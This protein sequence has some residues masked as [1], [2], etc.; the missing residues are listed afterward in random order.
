MSKIKVLVVDDAVVVRSLVVKVLG[1]DPDIEVVG[2]AANGKLALAMLEK[3]HPDLITLDI[4]MP[5]MN[6]IETL[7]HIRKSHP[8]LPVI[9]FSTLTERGASSTLE[10]LSRGAS[11]Y[12][13]KP[14]NTGKITESMEKVR[15]DL[16][17]KIKAL[18]A[19]VPKGSGAAGGAQPPSHPVTGRA[20]GGRPG[21]PTSTRPLPGARVS[22]LPGGAASAR[23]GAAPTGAN[24]T[25]T[26]RV[27]PVEIV[28]IGV[29]TGGPNALGELIPALPGNFPV[30][31]LIVQHM[32]P[33]FTRLLAERLDTRSKVKVVEAAPGM[34]IHPGTVY[35]APGEY[36]MTVRREGASVKLAMNQ[37]PPENS[38][39]PAVDPLFRSVSQVFG[40]GVLAVI[41][42]GMGS[43]GFHG[44][45]AVHSVGGR[46]LAQD[47]ATSVVWGMPG[48]VVK[49]KLA[50]EVLPLHSIHEALERLTMTSRRA[51]T[52]SQAM[53]S[54]E[55]RT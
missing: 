25:T 50:D 1:S 44:T 15:Q 39:R 52:S 22:A 7:T 30:P 46:V 29:S 24:R 14:S 53:S 37:D 34:A 36:H 43:D 5:E 6:G 55:A 8:R 9:M 10:A 28:V 20:V 51:P 3:C 23:T 21:S 4:E 32:P 17:P 18:C 16:I 35:V 40:A 12:V 26:R 49:A 47:E 54:P 42:T 19:G 11:D 31:I 33:V 13:T 48:F 27:S 45:E 38:C 2:T 41:L